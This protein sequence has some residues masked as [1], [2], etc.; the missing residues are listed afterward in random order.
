MLFRL[1]KI[2]YDGRGDPFI[3]KVSKQRYSDKFPNIQDAARDRAIHG[4]D[5]DNEYWTFMRKSEYTRDMN[6]SELSFMSRAVMFY[7][8]TMTIR[9]TFLDDFIEVM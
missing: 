1:L 7:P 6:F 9:P 2:I 5:K 3:V 8:Y 4:K